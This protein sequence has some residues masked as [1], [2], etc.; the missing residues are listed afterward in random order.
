MSPRCVFWRAFNHFVCPLPLKLNLCTYS[1]WQC[2]DYQHA[3]QTGWA[4]TDLT[5]SDVMQGDFCTHMLQEY[6]ER[7]ETERRNKQVAFCL[8]AALK[9]LCHSSP[10]VNI[11]CTCDGTVVTAREDGVVCSWSPELKPQQ[12]KHIFVCINFD[13]FVGHS[14]TFCLLSTNLWKDIFHYFKTLK[15]SFH[16]FLKA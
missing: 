10:I 16:Y 1:W 14:S 4:L 12:I 7:Q 2:A 11:H 15:G 3:G 6:K 8:P 13:T 5:L 9:T